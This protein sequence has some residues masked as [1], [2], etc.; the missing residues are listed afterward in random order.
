MKPV[1]GDNR[2]LGAVLDQDADQDADQSDC[3]TA[4]EEICNDVEPTQRAGQ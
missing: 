3:V 4:Q 1:P 2:S